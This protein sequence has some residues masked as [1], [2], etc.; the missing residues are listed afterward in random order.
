MSGYPG[1]DLRPAPWFGGG[2]SAPKCLENASRSSS[3][4]SW[5][6]NTRTSCR[7][8]AFLTARTCAS[9]AVARSTP[10]ISAPT[11]P[12]GTTSISNVTDISFLLLRPTDTV[13]QLIGPFNARCRPRLPGYIIRI[14][15]IPPGRKS[16]LTRRKL[17]IGAI[18]AGAT[19]H[20]RS[21][22]AKASQPATPVNFDVPAG[23]CACHSHIH[24]DPEKFPYFPGRVYTPETAL[25]EEM[26]ALHRALRLQRVVIV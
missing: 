18:A 9:L 24:G 23:A 15:Q 12:V 13:A 21:T 11:V 16:M 20:I 7:Y 10:R 6:R 26:A 5:L 14:R 1:G 22:F 4:I 19:M 25:P 8:Q 2:S 3:V 17:L